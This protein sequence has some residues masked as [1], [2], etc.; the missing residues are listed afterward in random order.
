EDGR[1]AIRGDVDVVRRHVLRG[2]RVVLS[3]VLLDDAREASRPRGR[4]PLE[5]HVLEE[6]REAR[7]PALL[8][9]RADAIP[10]LER[11]DG[12]PMILEEQHAEAVVEG[13]GEHARVAAG[14]RAR[15]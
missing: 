2:E 5:Y 8:V 1:D 6:V 11:H 14:L 9:A 4:R 7:V 13:G 15:R 12:A 10:D 3:A